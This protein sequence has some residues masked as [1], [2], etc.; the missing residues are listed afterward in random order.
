MSRRK[1][2]LKRKIEP[3]P[4]FHNP[5]IGKF[6]NGLIRKGK[7]SLAQKIFYSALDIIKEKTNKDSH[8]ILRKAIEN[9]RPS[10]EV[11]SRRVGGATYQVPIEV[12]EN[13]GSGLAIRWI[14]RTAKQKKGA[15]MA[16]RLAL[17]LIDASNNTG[18]AVKKKED[19]HKMAE[20]NRAFAHYKW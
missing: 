10:L 18:G 1:L 3:D 19:T 6:I 2:F 15:L 17:E 14:I 11:K 4:I 16:Q 12:R 20:A 8:D 9:V 5:L 7:K 13:R